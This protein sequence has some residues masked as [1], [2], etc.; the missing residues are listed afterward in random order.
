M[1]IFN[2]F[3]ISVLNMIAGKLK[4]YVLKIL[5][6]YTSHYLVSETWGFEGIK[7]LGVEIKHSES[8]PKLKTLY[9]ILQ[10]LKNYGHFAGHY[11]KNETF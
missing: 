1:K 7:G 3:V 6:T 5:L 11:V 10:F 8:T 4:I 9:G 2:F